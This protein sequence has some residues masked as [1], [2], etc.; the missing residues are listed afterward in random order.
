M[1]LAVALPL[2]PL[3]VATW[4]ALS[5]RARRLG[6]GWV[7]A[8]VAACPVAVAALAAPVRVEVPEML[9][10]GTTALV[11][12]DVSRAALLLFGG[13]WLTVGLLLTRTREAG[14]TATALLVALSGAM[15]LALAEGG[16]LVFAG[17]LVT[18][19]GLYAIMASE[20]GSHW[21][22]PARAL[23]VLLVLSDLL[24]FELLLSVTA[25]PGVGLQ[26][27][28]LLLGLAALML[29]SGMP[30]AHAWL[31]PALAAVG[32]PA[33]VLVVAVPTG[34]AL[35]GVLK[36]LPAGATQVGMLCL[37]LGLAGAIWAVI[38]G[39]AQSHARATLGYALAATAAS[40]LI[41]LPAGAGADGQLA[42][43]GVALLASCA[44][45][46]LLALLHSGR[47]RAAA[48]LVAL[49]VHGLAG[50][51]AALHAA[52]A[53]PIQA[54]PLAPL[55]AL[56]ATAL[57][58][59]AVRRTAALARDDASVAATRL[60]FAPV[61]V[62]C[63]GLGLGWSAGLPQFAA[64]WVAPA[65]VVLGW[66]LFQLL[67][68]WSRPRI[69]PGDVLGPVEAL[70]GL[71][72]RVLRVLCMR[73]LPRFRDRI[74]AGVFGL[75]NGA[76]WSRRIQWLDLGLRA[77]PATGLMMLLV[78]LGAAWLLVA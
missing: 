13:L 14:P 17:M 32:A 65:G 31:P 77:W 42:W 25:K 36:I 59:V 1:I 52:S 73:H 45:V 23:I 12:D 28:L 39:L 24:V 64:V 40:L 68:Q 49:A 60:A 57:L 41:A 26:P 44:V 46:P 71:L 35:I 66:V 3:A 67:P 8:L 38:A 9:L 18:G 19:Y 56:V 6:A 30:P 76:A 51:H 61:L 29:R 33:A 10:R 69:P 5:P 21:R 11:L 15:A 78:A 55:A 16:P 22:R 62:A 43:L 37:A 2:L 7:V 27:G 47:A 20:P 75:W 70:A 53:L 4:L 50:G 63:V 54:G 34:A 48:I 58:T 72:L 74:A